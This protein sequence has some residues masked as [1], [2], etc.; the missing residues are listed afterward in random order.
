MKINKR[1]VEI[2][3]STIVILILAVLVLVVLALYFTGGMTSLWGK[4]AG[5]ANVYSETDLNSA[6][7]K[8]SI[9]CSAEN[10]NNL[11]TTNIDITVQKDK[12]TIKEP[13]MCM[14][15]IIAAYNL[16]ECKEKGYN[17]ETCTA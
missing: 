10:I 5:I 3:I 17:Q 2:N 4:I 16:Q 1:G 15:N 13:H 14:D 11:C 6:R 8:C 9:Y 12:S 7:Q